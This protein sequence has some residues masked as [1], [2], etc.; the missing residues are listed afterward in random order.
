MNNGNFNMFEKDY[1]LG[2]KVKYVIN[3]TTKRENVDDEDDLKWLKVPI[4]QL[5]FDAEGQDIEGSYFSRKP[6]WPGGVSGI[7]IGRGFDVGQENDKNKI[8]ESLKKVSLNNRCKEINSELLNWLVDGTGLKGNEAKTHLST[9]N[10]RIADK[11][12]QIIT[13]KQQYYLFVEVLYPDYEEYGCKLTT[14][15]NIKITVEEYSKLP[16]WIRDIIVDLRYRG[17]NNPSTRAKFMPVLKQCVEN[18][19]YTEFKELMNNREYWVGNIKVPED[20][21]KRRK[22]YCNKLSGG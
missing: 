9:L 15:K 5:T 3:K 12:N 21:F 11:K 17:D 13:R 8:N 6:H 14:T 2:V 10:N 4:G 7:T 22:D 19:E 20:R 1:D 16:F 18:K